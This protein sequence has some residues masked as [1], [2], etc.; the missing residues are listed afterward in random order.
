[1]PK[2]TTTTT[3]T[4]TTPSKSNYSN[5]CGSDSPDAS[6]LNPNAEYDL[7]ILNVMYYF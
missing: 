4:A 5:G 7:T 6:V 1:M 3:T 2:T